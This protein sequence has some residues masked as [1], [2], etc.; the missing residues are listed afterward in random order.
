MDKIRTFIAIELLDTDTIS[1]IEHFQVKLNNS[2]GPL[3]I[4]DKSLFHIT[5][6][7]LGD[8]SLENAR[9]LYFFIE[10]KINLKYFKNPTKLESFQGVGDFNKKVFFIKLK[11]AIPEL[12]EIHKLIEDYAKTNLSIT[13]DKKVF[14]PH[15]TIARS[16]RKKNN[17]KNQKSIVKNSGQL[18]YGELKDKYQ[19][20]NFGNWT[21]EKVV[22]K[23]SVLTPKGPIYTN[24]YF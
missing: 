2:I 11:K 3:K 9:D 5:V 12:N 22:L 13:N 4:V 23:K 10:S 17:K 20:Y 24:L 6:K 19:N 7:F 21:L 1:N 15:L 18:S 16:K 8:I 14:N